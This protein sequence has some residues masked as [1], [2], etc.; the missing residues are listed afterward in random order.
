MITGRRLRL[1]TLVTKAYAGGAPG[2]VICQEAIEESTMSYAPC[3]GGT[4]VA[5]IFQRIQST[6]TLL[7][8]LQ[9]ATW[10]IEGKELSAP[11]ALDSDQ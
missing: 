8:L 11:Q 5:F 9:Q 10:R 2:D 7:R 4:L 3:G 6:S 1:Y